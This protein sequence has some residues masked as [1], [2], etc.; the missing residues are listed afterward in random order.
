MGLAVDNGAGKYPYLPSTQFAILEITDESEPWYELAQLG[1]QAVYDS[2]VSEI[3]E[4]SIDI[5]DA[6]SVIQPDAQAFFRVFPNP[7]RYQFQLQSGET[8][9]Q[10]MVKDNTGRIV[11]NAPGGHV[12]YVIDVSQWQPGIYIISAVTVSE[13]KSE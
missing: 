12:E 5:E 1:V 6:T 10:V 8:L 13:K 11:F 4:T 7:V 9:E 3:V 2:G